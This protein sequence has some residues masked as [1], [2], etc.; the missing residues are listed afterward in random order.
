MISTLASTGGP[1]ARTTVPYSPLQSPTVPYSPLQ[2]VP[3]YPEHGRT[4]LLGTLKGSLKTLKWQVSVSTVAIGGGGGSTVSPIAAL[5][6][7][8]V[9]LEKTNISL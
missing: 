5:L 2:S 4:G 9:K 3:S 6:I 8:F 7:Y 1:S